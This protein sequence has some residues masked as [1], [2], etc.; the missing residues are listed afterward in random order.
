MSWILNP[1]EKTETDVVNQSKYIPL[2]LL[3]QKCLYF[4]QNE[5]PFHDL[6]CFLMS[7]GCQNL[8]PEKRFP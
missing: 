6:H 8:N 5:D 1:F 7:H 3:C 4:L 2:N